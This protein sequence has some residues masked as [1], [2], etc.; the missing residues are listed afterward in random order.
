MGNFNGIDYV[1]FGLLFISTVFGIFR[2]FV[3][4][5]IALIAWVAAFVVATLYS[6]PF[7]GLF[8]S[9]AERAHNANLVDSIPTVSIIISYLALFFG[10]LIC[11]SIIKYIANYL[12]EGSGISVVNRLLGAVLGLGRG[13]I[14]V[15]LLIF[16]LGF[17]SLAKVML[18]KE[19]KTIALSQPA[20]VWMNKQAQPYLVVIQEK[21]K[22]TAKGLKEEENLSDVIKPKPE[23]NVPPVK[24]AVTPPAAP[25]IDAGAQ[26]NK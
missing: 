12:I 9:S 8:V 20:V 23:S 5:I 10:V 6:V 3:K 14:I 22:K 24:E 1:V 19:S 11:G 25:V 15:L 21:M 4:E 13:C 2:G 17:T 26:K 16:F 18:W 7:A